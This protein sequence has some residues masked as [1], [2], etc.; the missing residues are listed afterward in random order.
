MRHTFRSNAEKALTRAKKEL[1]SQEEERLKYA[2]L[3]LRLALEAITYDR[4]QGYR[5]KIPPRFYETWQPKRV[6][7]FLLQLDPYADR[8]SIV[9][10]GIEDTP[11]VPAADLKPYGE[12]TVLNLKN[13]KE[14]YDA[15]GSFL[16]MPTLG[17]LEKGVYTN[18]QAVRG[19]C[20]EIINILDTVFRSSIWNVVFR[21]LTKINCLKCGALIA[22][23]MHPGSPPLEAECFECGVTYSVKHMGGETPQWKPKQKEIVCPE[24][25]CNSTF[26]MWEKDLKRRTCWTCVDCGNNFIL[27]L[28]LIILRDSLP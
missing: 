27:D 1:E 18:Y 4:L 8:S 12:E 13:L 3:E 11:G 21:Y 23:N 22:K 7:Q 26:W 2:A 24:K 15:L 10:I 25:D 17:K 16:H 28:R 6:L 9:S 14:H 5:E 20:E 19:R